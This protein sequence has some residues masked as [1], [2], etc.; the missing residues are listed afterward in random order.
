M[1]LVLLHATELT[2]AVTPHSTVMA[3]DQQKANGHM[4]SVHNSHHTHTKQ[5]GHFKL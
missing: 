2:A 1:Q 3:N 4:Q 5:Y